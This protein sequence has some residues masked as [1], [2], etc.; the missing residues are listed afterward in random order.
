MTSTS[1][2]Q[3]IE[4]AAKGSLDLD[5]WIALTGIGPGPFPAPPK[6]YKVCSEGIFPIGFEY[7][8]NAD[9]K[10]EAKQKAMADAYCELAKSDGRFGFGEIELTQ[11]LREIQKSI[12][13]TSNED[14]EF[15]LLADVLEN[16]STNELFRELCKFENSPP[17]IFPCTPARLL[18]FIDGDIM[19]IF[20]VPDC[21]REAIASQNTVDWH[22]NHLGAAMWFRRHSIKPSE[23]AM[24]LCQFNPHDDR[25]DPL[26]DFNTETG[27]A[28]YKRLLRVF[29]DESQPR[30]LMQW[31]AV[32]QDNGL[33]YHSW[34][35]GYVNAAMQGQ[36]D[37]E[38]ATPIAPNKDRRGET[39]AEI[40]AVEWPMPAG[41]PS[42]ESILK[43]IPK[44]VEEACIKIGKVG[45]GP[46]GSHLWNPAVLAVCLA[47]QSPHKQWKCNT[48]A[49]TNFLRSEFSTYFDEWEAK[50]QML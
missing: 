9:N 4:L 8:R 32:A 2:E 16:S 17:L 47:S 13:Q 48:A 21:F 6:D 29:E 50:L 14:E 36:K 37:A 3:C 28:D 35:D 26:E 15:K 5:D 38:T 20:S 31:I 25:C 49:L 18:Q 44:Y 30:T 10:D 19:E 22:D 39:K 24:L 33:K 1:K 45:K 34:I 27:P 40:L 42:L 46:S 7:D 11:K 12:E 23:A 41:A 43:K